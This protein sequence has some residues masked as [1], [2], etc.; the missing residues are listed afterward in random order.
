MILVTR[1]PG[2]YYGLGAGR[3]E[4]TFIRYRKKYH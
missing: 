4:K 1:D 2:T 3:P